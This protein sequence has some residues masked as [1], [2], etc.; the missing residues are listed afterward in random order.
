MRLLR[1]RQVMQ[2]TGLSRM[3]IHRMERRGEFPQRRKVSANLVAWLED[4][5]S[6]WMLARP[7]VPRS[8][9][10]AGLRP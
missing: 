10:D 3:T 6:D 5:V 8:S 7:R 1:V 4:D 2:M 9:T